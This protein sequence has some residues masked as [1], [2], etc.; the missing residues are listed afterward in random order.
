M[1]E[2]EALLEDIDSDQLWD[3]YGG[4]VVYTYDEWDFGVKEFGKWWPTRND[5]TQRGKKSKGKKKKGD[6]EGSNPNPIGSS[7]KAEEADEKSNPKPE[8]DQT[9]NPNEGGKK[10]KKMKK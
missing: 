9:S 1:V 8:S 3:K 10:N 7:P 2:K 6:S 5:K 4:D